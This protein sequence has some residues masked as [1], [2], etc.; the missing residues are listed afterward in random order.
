MFFEKVRLWWKRFI[1]RL[2][3]PLSKEL[4]EGMYKKWREVKNR[5]N[6]QRPF[7]N[8]DG[9]S[10][11]PVIGESAF[12]RA[13][14]SQREGCFYC[15]LTNGDICGLDQS[16]ITAVT[17]GGH[18]TVFSSFLQIMRNIRED[19]AHAEWP[20]AK[21]CVDKFLSAVVAAGK[22]RGFKAPS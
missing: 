16:C 8:D 20:M 4:W 18:A 1:F 5:T 12:C 13:F 2:L 15:P 11:F 22:R 9:W 14:Y 6:Q 17:I 3:D 19:S 21:D 7:D 10:D